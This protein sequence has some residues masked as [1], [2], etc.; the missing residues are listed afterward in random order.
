MKKL[1]LLPLLLFAFY[2]CEKDDDSTEPEK[3]KTNTNTQPTYNTEYIFTADT[4]IK[5]IFYTDSEGDFKVEI[6]IDPALR[7]WSKKLKKAI[8]DTLRIAG[9]INSMTST[10]QVQVK[11]TGEGKVDTIQTFS[12][13]GFASFEGVIVP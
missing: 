3:T 11:Y 9:Q 8:G 4:S 7:T 2:A 10:P 1:F 13:P 12:S 6:S 5:Q